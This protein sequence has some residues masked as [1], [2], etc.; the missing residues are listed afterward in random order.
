[1]WNAIFG[2]RDPL[3][4]VLGYEVPAS[5]FDVLSKSA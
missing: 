4:Y 1:M 5:A 3:V 2:A